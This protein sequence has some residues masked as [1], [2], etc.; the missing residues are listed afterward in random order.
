MDGQGSDPGHLEWHSYR[1]PVC[2]HTD[3]VDLLRGQE[4]TIDCSHCGTTLAVVVMAPDTPAA[5]VTVS[6]RVAGER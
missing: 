6:A 3:G 4:R 5:G 1:C 2:G